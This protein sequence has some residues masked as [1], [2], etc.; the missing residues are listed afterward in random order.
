MALKP[1]GG[2]FLF[3]RFFLFGVVLAMAAAGS[4]AQTSGPSVP[5]AK[6]TE[7]S[8]AQNAAL[9]RKIE[10]MIRSELGVP[11]QY[12]LEIGT[13]QK[14]DMA[15]YDTVPVT[16][17]LPGQPG[18][19]Q[20]VDFLLSKDNNTLA[21]L[22]KWDLSIDPMTQLPTIGRPVRGNPQAKVTIVN[23]DDLECPYCARMHATF[24][25]ETLDRYK[26]LVKF[27]YVDYPLIEIHPWA[28]HAAVDANCLAAE[29]ETAYWNYVDYLHSH[30]A[31]V[32]GPDNDPKKAAANLDKLATQEADRDH[33]DGTKLSACLQKQDDSKIMAEMKS[34]DRLGVNATP[35]FFI[36]GERWAGQLDE[37]QLDTMI[38]R[39]LRAQGINPPPTSAAAPAQH[40]GK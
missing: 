24:F 12:Q 29:S 13:R 1:K 15:G 17:S 18:R 31:D 32:S 14:S 34:G 20:T 19:A 8:P 25:P 21:R 5:G 35:T 30:G 10:V 22:S 2:I 23:F 7:V 26:G 28:M 3:Q 9:N 16:F 4:S 27:V 11:P 36:N 33:L 37:S 38:D 40:A 6:P 39:A